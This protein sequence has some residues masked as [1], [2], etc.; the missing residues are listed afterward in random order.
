MSRAPFFRRLRPLNA[1]LMAVALGGCFTIGGSGDDGDGD[2]NGDCE[3]D[4]GCEDDEICNDG[5][6]EPLGSGGTSVGGASSGG[7]SGSS[8]G[9][10]SRGGTSNGGSSTGGSTSGGASSG[11]SSTGGSAGVPMDT[12]GTYCDFSL[13][14]GGENIGE[15]LS[16]CDGLFAAGGTCAS[17]LTALSSCILA[18]GPDCMTI[19]SSCTEPGQGVVAECGECQWTNDEECDEP[20]GTGYCPEGTDVNDCAGCAFALDGDCDEPEGLNLCPEGTDVVDCGC[21]DGM[22][23]NT[24]DYSCDGVCDEPEYCETGTDEYDCTYYPQ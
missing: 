10:S 21:P 5:I 22:A 9:G 4:S 13:R 14:C 12:C 8:T 15:C 18:Y 20:E 19:G 24:C 3:S 7:R 1:C 23:G 11:G 17:A 6:C 16:A 2:E